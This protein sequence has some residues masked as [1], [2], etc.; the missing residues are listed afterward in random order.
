M[1]IFLRGITLPKQRSAPLELLKIAPPTQVVLPLIQHL[2]EPATP[3]V[4]KGQKV[5]SGQ[6]VATAPT[7]HSV[8]IHT[9]LTGTVTDITTTF[10]S[11]GQSTDA[12]VIEG[13]RK[14]SRQKKIPDPTS[15]TPA[16]LTMRI[17]EAGLV[18]PG[19]QPLPLI[20]ELVLERTEGGQADRHPSDQRP[21]P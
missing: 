20:G 14:A 5:K 10:N 16:E 9:P 3:V 17:R 8:P 21:G 15:L 12:L 18:N 2:G 13:E 19:L 11:R 6:L 1:G 7:D 4:K